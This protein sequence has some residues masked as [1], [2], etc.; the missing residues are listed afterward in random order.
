MIEKKNETFTYTDLGFPIE[1]IDAPMKNIFGEWVLDINLN[2]LQQEVLKAL[3]HKSTPLQAGE[4]RFIRKYF[5]MTTTAFGEIFGVSHAAVIKW[6]SGQLPAPPMDLYIRMYAMDRL[7]A[8][9]A[10]FGKLFHE[11]SMAEL[12]QAKKERRKEKPLS[13]NVRHRKFAYGS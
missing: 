1:L 7:H 5:E 9:N 2:I 3:I 12:V 10:E 11:V 6:E 4:L 13:L 8:K